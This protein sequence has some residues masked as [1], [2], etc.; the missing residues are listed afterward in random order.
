MF[1]AGGPSCSP[2]LSINVNSHT[3]AGSLHSNGSVQI[4][5]NSGHI[6]GPTTYV[7]S[8]SGWPQSQFAGGLTQAE[9]LVFEAPWDISDYAPGSPKAELAADA[10]FH[11]PHGLNTAVSSVAPGLHFVEG[12]VNLYP[13][14]SGTVDLDGVTIVATGSIQISAN[15]VS[16]SPWDP[17]GVALFAN[18][19]NTPSCSA[20]AVQLSTTSLTFTGVI[21]APYGK[22]GLYTNSN[23]SISGAVIANV[24]QINSN[25]LVMDLP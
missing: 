25:T 17:D 9:P 21:F 8:A 13:S 12:N 5:A 22:V 11:H 18:S 10:Y 6:A 24:A 15:N 7:S 14:G 4:N 3:I 1:T 23:T 19:N 16:L 2:T 20:Q